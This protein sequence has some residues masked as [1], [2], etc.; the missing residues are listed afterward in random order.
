LFILSTEKYKLKIKTEKIM[1]VLVNE[2]YGGYGI[3][4]EAGKL[5][6]ERKAIPYEIYE[7]G[8]HLIVFINGKKEYMRNYISRT[9]ETLI[10]IFEDKG[11][12]FVSGDLSEVALIEIPDGC[13]YDI[14]EYDGT[15]YINS[16]WINI[17]LDELKNGLS[18]DRLELAQKV[19]CIRVV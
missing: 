1:K 11:S 17:T 10:E 5:W 19:S 15:E 18:G 3:S 2:C 9:D 16:T 8:F 12:K 14:H 6:L 13:E 4:T 7:D